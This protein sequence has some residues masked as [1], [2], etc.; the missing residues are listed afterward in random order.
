MTEVSADPPYATDLHTLGEAS[1]ERRRVM[2][3]SNTG[4]SIIDTGKA[5]MAA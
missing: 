2:R 3:R 4:P 1:E 5:A